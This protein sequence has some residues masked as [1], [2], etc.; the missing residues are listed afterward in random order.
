NGEN[1]IGALTCS[2]HV[3]PRPGRS[4]AGASSTGAWPGAVEMWPWPPPVYAG[5]GAGAGAGA[6]ASA[7]AGP[8]AAGA[9]PYA[10]DAAYVPGAARGLAPPHAAC[11]AS[12]V[13]SRTDDPHRCAEAPLSVVM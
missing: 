6:A 5:A 8:Y 4:G 12:T 13:R 9:G 11:A 3:V 1:V 7:G 2:P 10:P